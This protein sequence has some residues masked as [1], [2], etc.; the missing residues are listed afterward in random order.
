MTKETISAYVPG[1]PIV[2]VPKGGLEELAKRI[3]NPK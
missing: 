3:K 2:P 1:R